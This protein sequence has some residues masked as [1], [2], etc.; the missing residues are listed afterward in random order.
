MVLM[1]KADQWT[2]LF[3]LILS[4]LICGGSL[5]LPYGSV[6][7]PGPGF[8]PLWLGIILGAMSIGLILK[9]TRQREGAR[10]MRELLAEKFRWGKV[11]SVIIALLLYG[12]LMDSLGF[13]IVTFLFMAFLLWFVDPQPWRTVILW[14]LVGGLGS[15]LIFEVWL[16]LRLP[17]GFFG[18]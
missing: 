14:T 13:L 8:F 7:N 10:M 5:R 1:K 4:A 6:H 18:V 2:G 15:Y 9:T 16:K 11:I 17:K 3:L 12:L